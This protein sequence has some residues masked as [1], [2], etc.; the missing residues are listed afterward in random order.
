MALHLVDSRAFDLADGAYC[1]IAKLTND[2]Y[3]VIYRGLDSDGYIRTLYVNTTTNQITAGSAYEF[4][5]GITYAGGKQI[6]VDGEVRAIC[7]ASAGGAVYLTTINITDDGVITVPPIDSATIVTGTFTSMWS[8]ILHIA[9]TVYLLGYRGAGATIYLQT[10]NIANDGTI[11][12]A[13]QSWAFETTSPGTVVLYH[14]TGTVYACIFRSIEIGAH[15][16]VLFTVDIA[17]DGTITEAFI[18]S[19]TLEAADSVSSIRMVNI[20]G[21]TKYAI[22]YRNGTDDNI[23]LATVDIQ[24][25]GTIAAAITDSDTIADMD[26]P[27]IIYYDTGK[28]LVVYQN[29][30]GIEAKIYNINVGGVIGAVD[31]TKTMTGPGSYANIVNRT[32]KEFIAVTGS[33]SSG[34]ATYIGLAPVSTTQPVTDV[35]PGAAPGEGGTA[36]GHGNVTEMGEPDPNGH[37]HAWSTVVA[38]RSPY[39]DN[40]A[41]VAIGAFTSAIT[42]LKPGLTYYTRARVLT[43]DTTEYGNEESFISDPT[44]TKVKVRVNALDRGPGNLYLPDQWNVG[45]HSKRCMVKA[46]DGTL[47][48][49]G[50]NYFAQPNRVI[51]AYYS[52]DGGLT[53][54]Y[55]EVVAA[56]SALYDS[57][58]VLLVDS[59]SVPII[60]FVDN[61]NDA[62]EGIRYVDRRG[63]VWGVHELVYAT[64][65]H[66]G[67]DAVIDATNV[68]HITLYSNDIIYVKGVSGSWDAPEVVDAGGGWDPVIAVDSTGKPYI[69]YSSNITALVL[70]ERN[71]A[72][73]AEE[74]IVG[75]TM[76]AEYP[77]LAI[78][79]EDNLHVAWVDYNADSYIFYKKRTV[80]VWEALI[81]VDEDLDSE[82]YG[83]PSVTIDT[84]STVYV[85]YDTERYW[86]D[87]RYKRIVAG[88]LSAEIVLDGDV[89]PM[90]GIGSLG[91]A[92]YHRY[93]DSGILPAGMQPSIYQEEKRDTDSEPDIYYVRP[94]VEVAPSGGVPGVVELLT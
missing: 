32:G 34:R 23:T 38:P 30:T 49:A 17:D 25:D 80:G 92:I 11:G 87:I 84:G 2:R 60:L 27:D 48:I 91:S 86:P 33:L 18:D 44:I 68:I 69:V 7:H 14:I 58:F 59:D 20:A 19:L 77:S 4:Y 61:S 55:E 43:G 94:L 53:W 79:V 83:G 54:T 12:A 63:G 82:V 5:S 15:P 22:V 24:N 28:Y 35:A 3:T 47:W 46:P 57:N 9:G 89:I 6:T 74:D 93:P 8:D 10:R 26:D 78:D 72:W 52:I 67:L 37:G 62:N 85:I 88:V 42:R 29:S 13:I 41:V 64:T 65:N 45:N 51:Y 16:S 76:W 21:G 90:T 36:T 50:A 39:V 40:G 81:V 56:C 1:S 31:E 75:S 70:R 73:G 71:G 66:W